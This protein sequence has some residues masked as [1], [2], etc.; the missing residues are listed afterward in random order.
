MLGTDRIAECPEDVGVDSTKVEALF[1]RAAREV[2]A[3]LLPS[4]QLAIARDGRI[5]ARRTFGRAS[6]EGSDAE[7]TDETLYTI[8]SCTKAITSAAAW[9]LL[10]EGA[11]SLDDLV[12]DHVPGFG[13]NGKGD[14]RVEQLFLH[15]A[16]F[17]S[18][19]FRPP[20]FLDREKRRA[21]FAS[22]RLN[23]E[24][25]SRFE[26]HP[27]SSMYVIADIIES[28]SGMTFGDFVQAR[29]ARPLGLSNFFC[30]VPTAE[31]GRIADLA[32]AGEEMTDAEYEALG[33]KRPPVTEVTPE[34]IMGFNQPA[35][36]AAGI[37]GG[38]G[39]ASAS[40]LALFYQGLL[41]DA[42]GGEHAP[43]LW[44]PE[45]MADALRVRTGDLIDPLFGKRVNRGLGI[46]IAGD[47]DRTFRSF[48]HTNTE[49][50][51]G[52]AGAGGQI[53]WADPGTGLSFSYCTNGFDQH[54]I[55]MARRGIGLSSRAADCAL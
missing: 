12:T 37:P 39:T 46:V 25:G 50:A 42:D 9:L 32:L 11:F 15:T 16:G 52:H 6:F 18:A 44:K 36:R 22:W 55:R 38:G 2:E 7:A 29:V 4:A 43:G 53:A 54:A 19:P 45:T 5:A 24:P 49:Q 17:P 31:Q 23:W 41:H 20:E 3:G 34:A 13:E 1:E 21:R 10:Q 47:S 48:G 14:I 40:D 51:F 35:F 30:G 27:S 33:M 8:F 28:T 26:Y